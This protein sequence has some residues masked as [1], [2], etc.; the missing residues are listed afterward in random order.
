MR[1]MVIMRMYLVN[2]DDGCVYDDHQS[3]TCGVFETFKKA[4]DYCLSKNYIET[5]I[6][7]LFYKLEDS[8]YYSN[9][10][11]SLEIVEVEI[12]KEVIEPE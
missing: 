2:F 12:N 4:K 6:E 7:G 1:V 10:E 11:M 3:Y 9:R 8:R 5:E